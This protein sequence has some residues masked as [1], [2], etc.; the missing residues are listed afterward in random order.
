MLVA[1]D[2]FQLE[3]EALNFVV[4]YCADLA[5]TM[6]ILVTFDTSQSPIGISQLLPLRPF[7]VMHALIASVSSLLDSGAKTAYWV[8]YGV[9]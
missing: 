9:C 4:S 1:L 5:N 6:L 7:F 3:M 2:G 8:A